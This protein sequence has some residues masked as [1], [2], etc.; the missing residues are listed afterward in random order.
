ML[1]KKLRKEIRCVPLG[2]G[3]SS[4]KQIHNIRNRHVKNLA[5]T[6]NSTQSKPEVAKQ[7]TAA[8]LFIAI[9]IYLS[10]H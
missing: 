9:K 4:V 2:L 3:L 8:A 1:I 7:S 10:P 6:Y 5:R